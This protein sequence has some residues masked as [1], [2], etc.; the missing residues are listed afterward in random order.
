MDESDANLT[1]A[2][3]WRQPPPTTNST[4]P[5]IS[6]P[7]DRRPITRPIATNAIFVDSGSVSFAD[8]NNTNKINGSQGAGNV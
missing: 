1:S 4:L 6:Y 7:Q 5:N 2:V 8:S 3:C